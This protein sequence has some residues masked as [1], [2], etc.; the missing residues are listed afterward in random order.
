MS[1]SETRDLT[2]EQLSEYDGTGHTGKI[3]LAVQGVIFDVSTGGQEYYGEGRQSCKF[4]CCSCL[5]PT[6]PTF[7]DPDRCAQQ[8]LGIM[9]WLVKRWPEHW[10][11]CL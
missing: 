3:F 4:Y 7:L 5:Q 10:H 9:S 11:V 1:P 2:L 8:V 6:T